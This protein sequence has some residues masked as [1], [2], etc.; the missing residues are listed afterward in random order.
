MRRV[1][2]TRVAVTPASRS[3]RRWCDRVESETGSARVPQARS[4]PAASVATISSRTGSLQR[5]QHRGQVDVLAIRH[6]QIVALHST[7][8]EINVRT[9]AFDPSM[10][11][12]VWQ[13]GATR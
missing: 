10:T 4:P 8:I 3:T 1:P 5:V 12:E 6:L 2:S 9:V 7:V 11:V 13:R